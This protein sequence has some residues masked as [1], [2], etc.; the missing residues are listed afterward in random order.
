LYDTTNSSLGLER[1]SYTSFLHRSDDFISSTGIRKLVHYIWMN[2]VMFKK[3]V[4]STSV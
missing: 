2:N 4:Y 1:I 3:E